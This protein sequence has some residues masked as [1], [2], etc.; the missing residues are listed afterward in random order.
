[1]TALAGQGISSA[2]YYPIPLHRQEVFAE[3]H[4]DCSLPV[5]EHVA[6]QGKISLRIQQ[7]S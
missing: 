7:K 3:S 6:R 5:A 2:I 1:M 4:R